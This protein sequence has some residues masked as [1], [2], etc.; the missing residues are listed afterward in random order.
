MLEGIR[1]AGERLGDQVRRLFLADGDALVLP[2]RRLLIYLQAIRTHLPSV[3]RV[4]SYCLARNLRKKT[5]SEL[6]ELQEAGLKLAYLGAESGDDMVLARVS[7]GE[8]FASN[9]EALD[10][11]AQAGIRRSVMII[12]GLGG[13]SMSASHAERSARLINVTAPEYLST[14]M[15]MLS[16]GGARYRD[17]WPDWRPLSQSGL[18]RELERFLSGLELRRT[19]F[20]SDHASNWLA[21]KGTLGADKRRLVAQLRAAIE[22]PE[23]VPL[24]A[25]WMRGL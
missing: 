1:R 6:K 24:R 13:E 14:L 4:S 25:A 15:L 12:T 17:A 2:T 19:I 7:K 5:V 3:H 16:D 9:R 18:L 11:L 20:R 10:K 22:R 8:T 21:L 23:T